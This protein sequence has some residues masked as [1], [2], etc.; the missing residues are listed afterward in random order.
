MLKVEKGLR[1][2]LGFMDVAQYQTHLKRGLEALGCRVTRIVLGGDDLKFGP[3]D[4]ARVACFR[5]LKRAIEWNKNCWQRID[6]TAKTD[7]LRLCFAVWQ[8]RISAFVKKCLQ[9][10]SLLWTVARHDVIV[11][12]YAGS[13]LEP[14]DHT[15]EPTFRRFRDLKLIKSCGRKLVFTF[16]GSDSRVPYL[17]GYVVRN[18]RQL[19]PKDLIELT[20]SRRRLI[21]G[22]ER[23]ADYI[24]SIPN[25]TL[26]AKR[27]IIL[28][29]FLGRPFEAD[30]PDPIVELENADTT[31]VVL[32]APSSRH[33]K[34]TD[35][36]REVVARLKSKGFVF[37]YVEVIRCPHA[38][39]LEHMKRA[40][41][42]VDQM[43]SDRIVHGISTEAM[44]FGKPV[45]MAGYYVDYYRKDYEGR[46]PLPPV[47]FCR[48]EEMEKELGALL[49][50][51][52]RRRTLG[53]AGAAYVRERFAPIVVARRWLEMFQ[54]R[55]PPE[56]I[57]DP[58][59]VT[60]PF[61]VGLPMDE[62]RQLVRS[63]L[64]IGGKDALCLSDKPA[65][66]A[67]LLEL[68]GQG[69]KS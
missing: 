42:V 62:I 15:M 56:G 18:P 45:I 57:Y 39:L 11:L 40:S 43:F 65:V 9:W 50:D 12:S 49:K 24:M 8:Q 38:E 21:E 5:W 30:V 16:H 41:I 29:E 35:E 34:G 3:D 14:S 19:S 36:I 48:P 44:Y 54:G 31:P 2:F 69:A 28:H 47:V 58:K 51:P 66:E 46:F 33:A 25:Q 1:V 55:V 10:V 52:Q 59:S 32:H 7:L 27:P 60:Y 61:G 17:D 22:I 26:L 53:R 63:I 68:A 23:Y 67:A 37:E 13:F 20:K 64:Q 4:S 6:R